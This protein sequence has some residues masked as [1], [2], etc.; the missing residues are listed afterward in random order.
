MQTARR[1]TDFV[2]VMLVD[3]SPENQVGDV[4]RGWF[5][6]LRVA[7]SS[8]GSPASPCPPEAPSPGSRIEVKAKCAPPGA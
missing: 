3:V 2:I 8:F 7:W 5:E 1:A 6:L 4:V